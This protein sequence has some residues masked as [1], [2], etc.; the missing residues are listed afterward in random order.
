MGLE[1]LSLDG[2]VQHTSAGTA[3]LISLLQVRSILMQC[4]MSTKTI[5][6]IISNGVRPAINFKIVRLTR[7]PFQFETPGLHLYT[8]FI[9]ENFVCNV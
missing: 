6:V 8:E 7:A 3:L 9:S 1:A 5:T 4:V 2:G